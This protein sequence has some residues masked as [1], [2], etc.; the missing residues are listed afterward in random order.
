MQTNREEPGIDV[1]SIG[2]GDIKITYGD[3]PQEVAR[4]AQVVKDMLRRGYAL[5]VHGPDG[6]LVRVEAFDAEK[7]EYIVATGPD[8]ELVPGYV[9]EPVDGGSPSQ[10]EPGAPIV[11]G[12][13]RGPGRPR[14]AKAKIA[15]AMAKATMVGRSAGG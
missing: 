2:H 12:V 10:A 1:L 14:S 9:P 7:R 11:G 13:K 8:V 4:A 15:M 6:K 3:D 5:F